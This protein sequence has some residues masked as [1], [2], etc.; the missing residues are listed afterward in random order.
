MAILAHAA[1]NAFWEVTGVTNELIS[2][3]LLM[4]FVIIVTMI[5]DYF[6]KKHKD[7]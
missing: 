3:T 5:I 7:N 4:L 2:S 6:M 1:I